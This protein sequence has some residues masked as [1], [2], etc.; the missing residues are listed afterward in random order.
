MKR[1]LYSLFTLILGFLLSTVV[2]F[3][4][5][6]SGEAQASVV[7]Q[8]S[9]MVVIKVENVENESTLMNVMEALKAEGELSFTV[10]NG[11]IK[12]INGTSNP[13]DFSSCWMLYTSDSEMANS[14]WGTVEY[15]EEI[16]GSAIVGAETLVVSEGEYYIWWYQ[17]F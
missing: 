4:C 3:G 16:L 2:F 12:E 13:A 5:D 11:M 17:S 8:I 9:T 1:K 15:N 6:S 7:E 14:E 10:V